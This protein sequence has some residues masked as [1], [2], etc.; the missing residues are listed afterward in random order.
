MISCITDQL[1]MYTC[2]AAR[3]WT[4]SLISPLQGKRRY[5]QPDVCTAHACACSHERVEDCCNSGGNL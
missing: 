3:S 4:V 1:R 5:L 2:K